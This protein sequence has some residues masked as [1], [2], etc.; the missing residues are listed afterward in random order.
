MG[1]LEK[2]KESVWKANLDLYKKGLVVYTFGNVSG[3]DRESGL[4]VIKPSG[5]AYEELTKDMMVTVDLNNKIIDSKYNPST[6][7]KTH[8]VLYKNFPEIGGAV[9]MHS[10]FATSWAQAKKPIP[11]LGTTHADYS[12]T[13]IPCTDVM[14]DE[15]ILK[16]YE[17][18]TGVQIINTFKNYSY[19]YT[20][21]V[22]IACH[23]AFAWGDSP[24]K[25]VYHAVIL[26]EL[27]KMAFYTSMINPKITPLKKSLT[28]KH[29]FR[30]HGKNA[31]YG[32][33]K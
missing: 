11:C 28:D 6:D 7:T 18:E 9:H 10:T 21:M 16:D 17:E 4:V 25:A 3:I 14:T 24:D 29:F 20:P 32:Q 23:G 12:P 5:I 19:K 27:A 2:L 26:E 13:E 33:K 15:Q 8:I 22:L 1:S 31:Y 30:K